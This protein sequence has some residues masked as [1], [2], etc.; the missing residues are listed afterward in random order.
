MVCVGGLFS[1]GVRIEHRVS[2]SGT[3]LLQS[4]LYAR[5]LSGSGAQTYHER[6][7]KTSSKAQLS[8]IQG[9]NTSYFLHEWNNHLPVH[10]DFQILCIGPRLH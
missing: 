9:S 10:V 7:E 3:V 8:D 1:H 2:E 5:Q 6:E 4:F